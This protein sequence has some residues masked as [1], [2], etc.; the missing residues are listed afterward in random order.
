[1]KT[2]QT[3]K[4]KD[5]FNAFSTDFQKTHD[6]P[7][8]Y[9]LGIP[10]FD[11]NGKI[12]TARFLTIN[13]ETNRGVLSALMNEAK[14][15]KAPIKDV[16]FLGLTTNGLSNLILKNYFKPF[17]GEEGHTNID[18]LKIGGPINLC[19]LIYPTKESLIEKA[20]VSN[21]D[22]ICR[23]TAIS[24]LLFKPNQ[25]NLDGM[26]GLLDNLHYTADGAMTPAQWNKEFMKG[27]FIQSTGPD[28]IPSLSWGAPVPEGV[29]IANS[30]RVRLGAYLSLG[31][32]VIGFVNF[33]AGTLGACMVE[34]RISAGVTVG[35]D[36]DLGGGS[37]TMG[38]LSGG[39]KEKVSI[40]EN[41]LIGANGGTGISL[42]N[43]CTIE[44]GLYVTA[45]TVVSICNL[46]FKSNKAFSL[47]PA[48][49]S[50]W[51]KA[52]HLSGKDDMLFRR[53]S[54]DGN[55]EVLLN[56]KPNKLNRVLH[57]TASAGA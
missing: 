22:V 18:V 34:G 28:K 51:I 50:F 6:M 11:E 7:Y 26:F 47:F 23:L 1:M 5:G 44:A 17:E 13:I 45:G 8:A 25:I 20:P 12:I 21:V 29:R 46:K 16:T 54:K 42:G 19:A 49:P 40:G 53:N 36:S 41:C 43:R 32:T 33:N 10:Y 24:R 27:N 57:A 56:E 48:S 3:I 2:K 31:T 14:E 4:T 38:V 37:S 39:G 9:A 52:V 15:L 30:G 55:V 35:K